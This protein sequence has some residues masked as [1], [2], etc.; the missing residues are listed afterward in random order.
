MSFRSPAA[1]GGIPG[2]L[3]SLCKMSGPQGLGDAVTFNPKTRAWKSKNPKIALGF[4]GQPD[5]EDVGRLWNEG[6]GFWGWWFYLS[7]FYEVIDTLIIIMK[8][9]R[10]ATL[11]TYHHAGAMISMWAGIRYMS[12]PIWM[13]ALVNSGIHTLMYTYY[14]LSEVRIKVSKPLKQALTT[15]Q[16]MQFIVG[17]TFAS[18]HLFVYYS[19]P[20][21]V[22]YK[23]A[24]A[25]SSAAAS[26]SSVAS[27]A[28]VAAAVAATP[29]LASPVGAAATNSALTFFNKVAALAAGAP[30]VAANIQHGDNDSLFGL[31]DSQPLEQIKYHTTHTTIHCIDTSGQAF[32]IWLNCLYLAPLTALFVRFFVK[33]YIFGEPRPSKTDKG[34]ATGRRLSATAIS[35]WGATSRSLEGIGRKLER[36]IGTMGV[37]VKEGG[38]NLSA[39]EDVK[40]MLR[41]LHE[42]SE[43]NGK[44]SAIE[45]EDDEGATEEDGAAMNERPSEVKQEASEPEEES[46]IEE[47]EAP[48][49]QE[50]EEEEE[51]V[52]VEVE[53]E[54]DESEEGAGNEENK[55]PEATSFAEDVKSDS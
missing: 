20:V 46:S 47:I 23:V 18:A 38:E 15:M 52:E 25:I 16:I 54:E 40:K 7:K 51:E 19:V 8:G 5:N 27:S 14:T 13:F 55:K 45:D 36:T 6:L 3:D 32:A 11:Q 10:S 31:G 21:T 2:S 39:E 12:P 29:S 26:A 50:E 34:E 9:K 53:Q 49:K 44:D 24:Q 43:T 35:A 1:S 48:E 22:P 33:S 17:A 41:K 4:D 42:D 37:Q 30:G 28:S